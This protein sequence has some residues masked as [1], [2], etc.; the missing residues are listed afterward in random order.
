MRRSDG[1]GLAGHGLDCRSHALATRRC[2]ADEAVPWGGPWDRG[3]RGSCDDAPG[4][5]DLA[6]LARRFRG[7]TWLFRKARGQGSE[8]RRVVDPWIRGVVA[9]AVRR[10]ADAPR[11]RRRGRR[12]LLPRRIRRGSQS[13]SCGGGLPPPQRPAPTGFLAKKSGTCDRAAARARGR[14]HCGLAGRPRW[15]PQVTAATAAD[16]GSGRGGVSLVK[17]G[18]TL[19]SRQR[20]GC[21]CRPNYARPAGVAVGVAAGVPA[22][23][24]RFAAPVCQGTPWRPSPAPARS[25]AP[26]RRAAYSAGPLRR[27]SSGT[28]FS[29]E[30]SQAA[31]VALEFLTFARISRF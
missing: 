25:T 3:A 12:V 19:P 17:G 24:L 14:G 4:A 11:R 2:V 28:A 20:R 31:S 13:G 15:R 8:Q 9:N 27:G 6:R 23:E 16:H 1:V 30:G 22:D 7:G 10:T 26:T 29:V 21:R 5:G 18:A